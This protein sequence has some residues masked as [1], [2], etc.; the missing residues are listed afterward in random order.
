MSFNSPLINKNSNNENDLSIF[1]DIIFGSYEKSHSNNISFNSNMIKPLNFSF[2]KVELNDKENEERSSISI[3][4]T[5]RKINNKIELNEHFCIKRS[6]SISNCSHKIY[7]KLLNR[8]IIRISKIKHTPQIRISYHKII[9]NSYIKKKINDCLIKWRKIIKGEDYSETVFS[10][11]KRI[12]KEIKKYQKVKINKNNLVKELLPTFN[13]ELSQKINN[14]KTVNFKKDNFFDMKMEGIRI[15]KNVIKRK[16]LYF[17]KKKIKIFFHKRKI[18]K[19][20]KTFTIKYAHRK[21]SKINLLYLYRKLHL[22]HYFL[23]WKNKIL[24][25]YIKVNAG[26]KDLTIKYSPIKV[27]PIENND[28][29]NNEEIKKNLTIKYTPIKAIKKDRMTNLTI[30]EESDSNISPSY[31]SEKSEISENDNIKKNNIY[32]SNNIIHNNNPNNLIN[33]FNKTQTNIQNN[34]ENNNNIHN[35]N[36]NNHKSNNNNIKN[37]NEKDNII[38]N[39]NENNNIHNINKKDNIIQNNNYIYNI[40]KKDNNDIQNNYKKKNGYNNKKEK[41]NF[42]NKNNQYKHIIY[43]NANIINNDKNENNIIIIKNNNNNIIEN[44]KSTKKNLIIKFNKT[45]RIENDKKNIKRRKSNKMKSKIILEKII[46]KLDSE[47]TNKHLKN[48]F[49]K[50]KKKYEQEEKKIIEEE[51]FLESDEKKNEKNYK[52]ETPKSKKN[53]LWKSDI[54]N[55]NHPFISNEKSMDETKVTDDSTYINISFDGSENKENITFKRLNDKIDF[56]KNESIDDNHDKNHFDIKNKDENKI[57]KKNLIIN[58][59][60]Q[61]N[62]SNFKNPHKK[63]SLKFIFESIN[64]KK[65]NF[66][67]KNYLIKWNN[68]IGIVKENRQLILKKEIQKQFLKKYF[69]NWKKNYYKEIKNDKIIKIYRTRNIINKIRQ[70]EFLKQYLNKWV[71]VSNKIKLRNDSLKNK[72]YKIERLYLKK[73]MKKALVKYNKV[74]NKIQTN[75][76]YKNIILKKLFEK[77]KKQNKKKI[78]K[79]NMNIW[80]KIIKIIDSNK[81]L[82]ELFSHLKIKILLKKLKQIQFEVL[83]IIYSKIIKKNILKKLITNNNKNIFN[84]I[85]RYY[86][87]WRINTQK[88][89]NKKIIS[90]LKLL[91]TLEKFENIHQ[92][93]IIKKYFISFI[94]NIR[95]LNPIKKYKSDIN[96]SQQEIYFNNQSEKIRNGK[97]NIQIKNNKSSIKPKIINKNQN[98]IN[99]FVIILENIIKKYYFYK[100]MMNENELS[101]IKDKMKKFK[102]F[103]IMKEKKSFFAKFKKRKNQINKK[104][105]NQLN[106]TFRKMLIKKLSRTLKISG[107][108]YFIIYLINITIMHKKVSLNRYKKKILRA[109]RCYV[110]FTLMKLNRMKMMYENYMKTFMSLSNDLFGNYSLEEKSIQLSFAEFLEKID[111]VSL[112]INEKE[113]KN[114]TNKK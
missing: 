76:Q 38:Y 32:E 47:C 95:I 36:Q 85:Q 55:N 78:L 40:N 101:N 27:Y 100:L 94:K 1:E 92:K 98:I 15:I 34:H 4:N 41:Y 110:F 96:G 19:N 79:K 58:F 90:S 109:W 54:I 44:N 57:I 3:I 83:N 104:N 29:N 72:L 75:N 51:E 52:M 2:N 42:I 63:L 112:N 8:N 97:K 35:I 62:F 24:F 25:E 61:K 69:V 12:L 16:F 65:N 113:K 107:R 73:I 87:L 23:N 88:L 6:K 102:L 7:K 74:I 11:A 5:D 71:N 111:Y 80:Y 106:K 17:I 64:K 84:N 43:N 59:N 108:F 81:K 20:E 82:N 66:I 86:S 45:K 77:I 70:N 14:F 68:I 22:K 10:N 18:K 33:I 67:I 28:N 21:F 91:N 105:D 93:Q 60:N 26:I 99:K 39:Y 114:K 103:I 89:K 50:W 46:K 9:L 31:I 53:I 49:E 13:Y 30:I 48:S 37:I 56:E